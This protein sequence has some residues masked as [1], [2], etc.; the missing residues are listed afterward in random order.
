MQISRYLR[1]SNI[2]Q[3]KVIEQKMK[4]WYKDEGSRRGIISENIDEWYCSY[5]DPAI[6][7][8]QSDGHSCGGFCCMYIAYH[9]ILSRLPTIVDFQQLDIQKICN[10]ILY[11]ILHSTCQSVHRTAWIKQLRP[12]QNFR[13]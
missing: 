3:C 7:S 6:N 2:K 8:K 5:G 12:A 10:Y 9:M 4:L 11:T 1:P 13:I